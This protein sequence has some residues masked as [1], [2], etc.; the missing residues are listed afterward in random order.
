MEYEVYDGFFDLEG[1]AGTNVRVQLPYSQESKIHA[2]I[3]YLTN[4]SKLE[5]SMLYYK[6]TNKDSL[7]SILI[8]LEK[9]GKYIVSLIYL[10]SKDK[11]DI[12]TTE[13]VYSILYQYYIHGGIK[14]LLRGALEEH[15]KDAIY[16]CKKLDQIYI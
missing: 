11:R 14:L 9:P 12:Y 1:P 5:Q 2:Y 3:I 13:C 8:D 7:E 4:V 6:F 10:H 16:I 15:L